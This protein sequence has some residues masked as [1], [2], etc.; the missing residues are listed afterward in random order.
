MDHQQIHLTETVFFPEGSGY[1]LVKILQDVAYGSKVA[2]VRSITNDELYIRKEPCISDGLTYE[3]QGHRHVEVNT[4]LK[5]GD[6]ARTPRLE[7]WTEYHDSRS[8][9][10]QART[11]VTY[12]Q[13]CNA[14]TLDDVSKTLE[15]AGRRMPEPCVW[16]IMA[17]MLSIIADMHDRGVSQNDEHS[18]NWFLHFDLEDDELPRLLLGDLDIARIKAGATP[19]QWTEALDSSMPRVKDVLPSLMAPG[20]E[21]DYPEGAEILLSEAEEIYSEALMDR[22]HA[23]NEVYVGTFSSEAAFLRLVRDRAQSASD[24]LT[25]H[26]STDAVHCHC[27]IFNIR[28]AELPYCITLPVGQLA[29]LPPTHQL[30][31]FVRWGIAKLDPSNGRPDE[32]VKRPEQSGRLPHMEN[33]VSEHPY[34]RQWA[35]DEEELLVNTEYI[36]DPHAWVFN[37]DGNDND[38]HD[39]DSDDSDAEAVWV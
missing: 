18:G 23:L 2:I 25:Q 5:L 6:Y 4:Y 1:I 21:P 29:S 31:G 33:V 11:T 37:N 13:Y 10:E 30:Q 14:G 22:I 38:N 12:W 32:V 20:Y 9:H 27:G 39:N 28:S 34:N 17:Q 16:Y 8:G 15:A 19:E 26:F 36:P 35:D 3:Y 24:Y 7:G